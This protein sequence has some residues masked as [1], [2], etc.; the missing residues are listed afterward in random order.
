MQIKP[1]K[2]PQQNK[3]TGK[4][5]DLQNAFLRLQY[6]PRTIKQQINKARRTPRDNLLQDRS[7][8]PKYRT[9]LVVTYSPQVRP[10]THILNDLQ[11]ILKK[12]Y[13]SPNFL[14]GD[15]YLPT[16]NLPTSNKY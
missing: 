10:L 11:L 7:K 1:W 4:L 5:R 16:D 2:S 8:V 9:P 6:P 12:T 3:E 13:H 14:V 15:P